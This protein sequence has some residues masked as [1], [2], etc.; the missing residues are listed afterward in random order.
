MVLS[1]YTPSTVNKPTQRGK[2]TKGTH[3]FIKLIGHKYY[4]S[5]ENR[6]PERQI[7]FVLSTKF[8]L[9]TKII[10]TY[11]RIIGSY[12]TYHLRKV[13]IPGKN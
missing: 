10:I 13:P 3:H 8:I 7:Q 2:N 1:Q 4:R 9:E 12:I 6:R 5:M 11:K